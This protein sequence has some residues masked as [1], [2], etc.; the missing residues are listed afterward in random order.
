ME[1]A[2]KLAVH[3]HLLRLAKQVKQPV[4]SFDYDDAIRRSDFARSFIAHPYW[5]IISRML[6]GTI[7]QETEEMLSGDAH[8]AV[9]RASVAICRKVLQMPFF[10]IEQG[11]IA[12]STYEYAK[13]QQAKR[14]VKAPTSA[15]RTV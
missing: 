10:D 13:A 8:L 6:S 7:Q 14:K 9:N 3:A 5:E 15:E 12:E 1:Q 2:A 11:R 4:T